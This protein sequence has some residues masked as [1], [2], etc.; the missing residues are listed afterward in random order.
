MLN[1]MADTHENIKWHEVNCLGLKCPLPVIRFEKAVAAGH[2][3]ILMISDDPVS[4]IDI[5]LAAQQM[6]INLIEQHK[7]GTEFHFLLK[8][9]SK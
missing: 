7:H 3:D 4:V 5:P 2:R 9:L 1:F 8:K 6:G